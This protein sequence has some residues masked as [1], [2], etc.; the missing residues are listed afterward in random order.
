MHVAT[1][2]NWLGNNLI[3]VQ[4]RVQWL[5]VVVWKIHLNVIMALA[6]LCLMILGIVVFRI[7]GLSTSRHTFDTLWSFLFGF[8][9]LLVC[10]RSVLDLSLDVVN[11]FVCVYTCSYIAA[12]S[13]EMDYKKID[14]NQC[15]GDQ[16]F[17]IFAGTHKCKR[18]TTMVRPIN[19]RALKS[20]NKFRVFFFRQKFRQSSFSLASYS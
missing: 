4:C 5:V 20:S 15:D 19:E 14:I 6:D 18:E 13:V 7:Q 3:S 8:S 1:N 17:N 12:I 11:E 10:S 16:Q 9:W 2:M